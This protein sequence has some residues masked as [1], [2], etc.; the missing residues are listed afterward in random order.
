M[1]TKNRGLVLIPLMGLVMI[2]LSAVGQETETR[3]RGIVSKDPPA[4]HNMLVIGT[5]TAFCPISPCSMISIRGKL[6]I[7]LR[8]AIR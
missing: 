6:I 2:A 7:R 1:K 8:T 3:D 4:T 5:K